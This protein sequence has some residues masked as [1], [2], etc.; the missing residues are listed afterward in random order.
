MR[1]QSFVNFCTVLKPQFLALA[2]QENRLENVLE[3]RRQESCELFQAVPVCSLLWYNVS[4]SQHLACKSGMGSASGF[5]CYVVCCILI[6][7]KS[8]AQP[9]L[10]MWQ[11]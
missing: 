11:D 8:C 9:Y 10:N 6:S 5:V 7:F 4:V 1:T 2:R 3:G